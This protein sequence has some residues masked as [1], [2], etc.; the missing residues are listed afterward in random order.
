MHDSY[1][2][3]NKI[4][5]GYFR[6]GCSSVF[7]FFLDSSRRSLLE[8]PITIPED[9]VLLKSKSSIQGYQI[10]QIEEVKKR[11]GAALLNIHPEPHL[12]GRPECLE[13]LEAVLKFVSGDK[14]C[15]ICRGEDIY[16]YWGTLK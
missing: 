6:D 5:P 12:T 11:G 13:A 9:F 15:W 2:P 8:L 16:N 10:A 7:P 14:E 1:N 3:G 4:N